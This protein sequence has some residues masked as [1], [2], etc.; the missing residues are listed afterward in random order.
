MHLSDEE[1]AAL[2]G[3]RPANLNEEEV[4][5][6]CGTRCSVQTRGPP[7]LPLVQRTVFLQF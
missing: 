7:R 3:Y 5:V 4:R 6:A 2:R 1:L